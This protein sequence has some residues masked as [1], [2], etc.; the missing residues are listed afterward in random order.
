MQL[1]H[2]PMDH[3]MSHQHPG[4]VGCVGSDLCHP[5]RESLINAAMIRAGLYA[6]RGLGPAVGSSL[7]LG[8]RSEGAGTS[9]APGAVTCQGHFFAS[10]STDGEGS[11]LE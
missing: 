1:I 6:T 2:N 8:A 5:D 4:S 9:L 3:A 7:L 11:D 10:D